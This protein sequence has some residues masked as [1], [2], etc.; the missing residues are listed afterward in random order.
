[1]ALLTFNEQQSIKP[2][3]ANNQGKYAQLQKDVE[4]IQLPRLLGYKLAQL[5]QTTPSSYTDLLNGS[6]FAYCDYTLKHKGL[7]YCLAY[8]TY[9]E[10]VTQSMFE[11]TFTGFQ[12]QN[13]AETTRATGGEL[14]QIAQLSINAAET[15]FELVKKYIDFA[16]LNEYDKP[17]HKARSA[18]F[19]N[20]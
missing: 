6:E 13:R 20:I 10:Y 9:A 4:D 19:Y 11:D 14:K 3:S 12:H 17:I 5:V 16:Q 18:N 8:F 15:A 2:I 1:M 7:K